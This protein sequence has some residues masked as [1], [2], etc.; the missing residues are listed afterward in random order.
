V[1]FWV[2]VTDGNW[3]DY[4]SRV[5][6]EEVNFWQPNGAV[7]Y[8]G[9][10]AGDVFLFKL[11]RPHNH[12]AGGGF[13]VRSAAYPASMVWETFGQ[14]NGAPDAKAFLSA[15][16][17]L[18]RSSEEP[19]PT[20]GCTVLATPFFW[21]RDMWIPDPDGWSGNI[22]RG[23]YYDTEAAAGA[24]LWQKVVERLERATGLKEE[25]RRFG[26]DQLVKPRLGQGGFRVMVT[27]AYRR[28]CAMTGESTLPVLDA[29]HILPYSE[30]GPHEVKNGLLLRTDFHKLFDQGL[31]TVTPELRVEVSS[32]IR[33][34]W[35]NGKA[36]YRLHGQSLANLPPDPELRPSPA[37]LQWHNENRFRA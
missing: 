36:Y 27:E 37:F 25:V 24:T 17:R 35:F 14:R 23:R 29:A 26:S 15:I 32:R 16:R 3:F 4:L 1:K 28:R 33:E 22:V 7:A 19:D 31:V 9:L 2:G 10:T 21:P 30:R 8:A 6:Q 11:K 13:F 12:I 20:V 5:Q 34:E 18:S